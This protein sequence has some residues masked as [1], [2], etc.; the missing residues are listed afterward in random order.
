MTAL[1]ELDLEDCISLRS[2]PRKLDGLKSAQAL[3]LSDFCSLDVPTI[4][5]LLV[6]PSST[7]QEWAACR[8]ADM[9]AADNYRMRAECKT[10]ASGL[11]VGS[12]P[13]KVQQ[14]RA[15]GA[16]YCS[17]LAAIVES[18]AVLVLGDRLQSDEAAV[19]EQA[20]R[21]V[22][23]ILEACWNII[24]TAKPCR[25]SAPC[26][27]AQDAGR[28]DLA[29]IA[30]HAR[31]IQA[32]LFGLPLVRLLGSDIP[33]VRGQAVRAVKLMAYCPSTCLSLAA[34]GAIPALLRLLETSTPAVQKD[35]ADALSHGGENWTICRAE[36]I[37][38]GLVRLLG[39]DST[40]TQEHAAG[41]LCN[42]AGDGHADNDE[43]PLALLQVLESGSIAVQERAASVLGWQLRF[44]DS[45]ALLKEAS[46]MLEALDPTSGEA[47]DGANPPS[48]QHAASAFFL[49]I[50]KSTA[51]PSQAKMGLLVKDLE[52]IDCKSHMTAAENEGVSPS[53]RLLQSTS[54]LLQ[55]AG[56]QFLSS[57]LQV[58]Y[59][60]DSDCPSVPT[61]LYSWRSQRSAKTAQLVVKSGAM[62]CV[63]EMTQTPHLAAVAST[64]MANLTI[65]TQARAQMRGSGMVELL[66]S[67]IDNNH[68]RDVEPATSH[69]EGW[70][71]AGCAS[72]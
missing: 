33:A 55:G 19:Q 23:N 14:F 52:Q 2:F 32:Q 58:H 43:L 63:L 46:K 50:L 21:A 35:A 45:D 13:P 3:K 30:R 39:S 61:Y 65:S 57:R 56:A 1:K 49:D 16:I 15:A 18:G 29:N 10:V 20:A 31:V 28:E 5:Q 11:Q 27:E 34:E 67:R 72:R 59:D 68:E 69:F 62:P 48:F 60:G 4:V 42:L 37:M 51:P 70:E 54:T 26:P 36:G 9:S 41:V 25:S 22:G 24:Q 8:L 12:A 7:V 38:P 44:T 66:A 64:L 6:S 53:I 47:G 40:T 17:F 71:V